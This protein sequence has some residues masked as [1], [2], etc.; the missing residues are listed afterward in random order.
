MMNIRCS[1]PACLERASNGARCET[2]STRA[3]RARIRRKLKPKTYTWLDVAEAHVRALSRL[4][5][6]GEVA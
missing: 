4:E 6:K 1:T 2:C 3:Q 5:Q